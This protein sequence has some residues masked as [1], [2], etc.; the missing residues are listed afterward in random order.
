MA[1]RSPAQQRR[2]QLDAQPELVAA[3]LDAPTNAGRVLLSSAC[4]FCPNVARLRLVQDAERRLRKAVATLLG[5]RSPDERAARAVLRDLSAYIH[6]PDGIAQYPHLV[7]TPRGLDPWPNWRTH[8]K[9]LAR[10]HPEW[11]AA[12]RE[13]VARLER[14]ERE[15]AAER[16]AGTLIPVAMPPKLVELLEEIA[17]HAAALSMAERAELHRRVQG[18]LFAGGF[19][20]CPPD[21]VSYRALDALAPPSLYDLPAMGSA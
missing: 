14:T 17:E 20:D 5:H 6:R 16:E 21:H 12:I 15:L 4:T 8:L 3:I 11:R 7:A 2:R 9:N 13:D 19:G 10:Q 1:H 18:W